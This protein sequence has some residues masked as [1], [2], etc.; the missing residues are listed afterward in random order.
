MKRRVMLACALAVAIA[1]QAD[2]RPYQPRA[3]ELGG[4]YP[5]CGW[6]RTTIADI[7]DVALSTPGM[8]YLNPALLRMPRPLQL[9]WYAHECAHQLFGT[10]EGQADCWA[11]RIGRH[12]GW[13]QQ[14]DF[15]LLS[16]T[17]RPDGDSRH[18]P[19]R[20]RIELLR[21][22]FATSPAQYAGPAAQ[23]PGLA[24]YA[25]APWPGAYQRE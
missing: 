25:S 12:E 22:C 7:P 14:G 19:A 15:A 11:I 9:F 2:A 20:Q 4:A 16:W 1:P 23:G 21:R 13:F 24:S 6:V 3:L 8:I 17:L 18:L 5:T 10:S